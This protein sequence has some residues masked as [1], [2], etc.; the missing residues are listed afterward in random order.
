MDNMQ[1]T[2]DDA[3]D[4]EYMHIYR[5]PPCTWWAWDLTLLTWR[6]GNRS[7]LISSPSK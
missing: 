7:C 2:D 4:E 6:A 1:I 5:T 3:I